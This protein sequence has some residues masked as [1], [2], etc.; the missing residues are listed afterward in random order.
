M[1]QIGFDQMKKIEELKSIL[2]L[3][4]VAKNYLEKYSWCKTIIN[5]WYDANL[6]IHDKIGI[7]LFEIE[8]ID[9]TVDDFVWVING[10]LPTVYLDKSIET[11]NEALEVY[12]NLMSEWI[13][14]IITGH[15][16][17]DCYP[18]QADPTIANAELLKKRIAFIRKELLLIKQ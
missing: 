13:D 4:D 10:D 16:I 11:S 7:F 6:G 8:P 3:Y 5:G 17:S 15:S 1:N 18:V 14:N 9:E 2:N 12:C